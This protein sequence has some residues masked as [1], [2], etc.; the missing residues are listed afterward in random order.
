M[1]S[2]LETLAP[3]C[4]GMALLSGC[5]G[6]P[7]PVNAAEVP[8]ATEAKPSAAPAVEAQTGGSTA[9]TA[10]MAAPSASATT[11][12]SAAAPSAA[13]P[14]AP[15]AKAAVKVRKAA[16][17]KKDANGSCGAGTCG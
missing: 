16:A 3:L 7:T 14:A 15:P 5:G 10:V 6:A 11:A 13:A 8:A 4:A 17:V 9:G 2:L 1:K 12:P